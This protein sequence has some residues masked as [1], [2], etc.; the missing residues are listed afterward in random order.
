MDAK[1]SCLL[2]CPL[3]ALF[4]PHLQNTCKP[5]GEVIPRAS[6]GRTSK[7]PRYYITGEASSTSSG[8][9]CSASPGPRLS[10]SAKP[11][12]GSVYFREAFVCTWGNLLHWRSNLSNHP[13]S[14][15]KALF[16]IHECQVDAF[17]AR[18]GL[19]CHDRPAGLRASM[20]AWTGE[21]P[22][23]KVF[24]IASSSKHQQRNKSS[25][26]TATGIRGEICC[27]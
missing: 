16:C 2:H 6:R 15:L 8:I 25:T 27:G 4:I 17:A 5:K 7:L 26:A 14:I 21:R 19:S 18:P 9:A 1:Y 10:N 20:G 3:W 11:R 24:R 23:K 22:C 12:D 13:W